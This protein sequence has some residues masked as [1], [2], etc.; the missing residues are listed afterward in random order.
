MLPGPGR[1]ALIAAE[2]VDRADEEPALPLGAQAQIDVE[3]HARGGAAREPAA[4]ALCKP[5]IDLLGAV[6]GIV[7]E[8]NEVEVGRVAKLLPAELAVGDDC[9]ARLA[10]MA[11]AQLLPAQLERDLQHR[12][13]EVR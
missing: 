5:R 2:T 12:V 13:G 11:R 10:S 1:L 8:K 3:E 9:E 6:V 4:H 7:V